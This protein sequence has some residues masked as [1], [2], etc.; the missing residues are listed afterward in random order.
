[1]ERSAYQHKLAMELWNADI[2]E[3]AL[4]EYRGEILPTAGPAVLGADGGYV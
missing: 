4:V 3:G 1:M 2:A